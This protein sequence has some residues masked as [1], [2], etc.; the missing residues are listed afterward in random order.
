[1]KSLEMLQTLIADRRQNPVEGSYTAK[2]LADGR[3]KVAQKVGEEAVEVVVAALA[4]TRTEQVYELGDLFFHLMVLMHQLGISLD[5][6]DVELLRRQ[7]PQQ[8][9]EIIP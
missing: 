3:S 1:M 4:Q 7:A 2:L 5:D 6:L 9:P 8:P